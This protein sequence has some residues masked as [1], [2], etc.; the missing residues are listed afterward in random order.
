[1]HGRGRGIWDAAVQNNKG[2]GAAPAAPALKFNAA[3]NSQYIPIV[4]F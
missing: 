2:S 3:A 4:G 1:M